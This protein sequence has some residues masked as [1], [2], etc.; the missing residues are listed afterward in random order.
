MGNFL[1]TTRLFQKEVAYL[2][3]IVSAEGVATDPAKIDAVR[4]WLIPTDVQKVRSFFV[5]SVVCVRCRHD[6]RS[7]VAPCRQRPGLSVD[8]ECQAAFDEL[9]GLDKPFV[10]D[11]DAS[12][13]GTKRC[14]SGAGWGRASG[15]I[16]QPILVQ[17]GEELLRDQK[18]TPG[19]GQLR[20]DR[21]Y[22]YGATFTVRTDHAALKWLLRMKEP[23]RQLARWIGALSEYDIII[24]LR[25]DAN[26]DARS[27][28][29]CV[30]CECKG[31]DDR[32]G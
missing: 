11:C 10:R 1:N 18:G 16:R 12:A 27:R 15:V 2:G 30:L 13:Y 26:A 20:H 4:G 24:K 28:I 6:G 7:A 9:K 31:Y 3:H 32:A 5:L 25:P 21:H 19:S 29:P 22:P 14:T 8:H 23:E 17:D